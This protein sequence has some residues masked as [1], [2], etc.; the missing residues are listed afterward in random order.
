[1]SQ[2][3]YE[4][5]TL[6]AFLGM[7]ADS[8]HLDA[9][10]A[11]VES[12]EAANLGFGR[13]VKRGSV[14]GLIAAIDADADKPL[15]LLIHK[16]ANEEGTVKDGDYHSVMRKGRCYVQASEAVVAGDKAYYVHATG[17]FSKTAGA[18]A[19]ELVG[20]EFKTSGATD[21]LVIL[22]LNLPNG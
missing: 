12:G 4:I 11:C 10:S 22:E 20:S 13:M 15:G 6:K 5:N 18:G 17:K 2:T 21:E 9:D 7:I 8:K 16:A 14:D 19:I 3:S 1:M